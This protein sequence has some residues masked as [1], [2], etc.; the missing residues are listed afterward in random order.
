MKSSL[1]LVWPMLILVG[2]LLVAASACALL[3]P[4]PTLPPLDPGAPQDGKASPAEVVAGAFENVAST[5]NEITADGVVTDEESARFREVYSKMGPAVSQSWQQLEANF[6][7]Q[8][9]AAKQ[10]GGSVDWV[11]TGINVLASTL[12]GSAGGL[13]L[14]RKVPNRI[15]LGTEHDPEVARVAG[16]PPPN[17]V[18]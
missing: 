2:L 17:A 13:A 7:A 16:T 18:Q 9:E 1:S 8:V 14:V 3:Q 10:A 12:L 4:T 6:R 5:W 15:I 11:A